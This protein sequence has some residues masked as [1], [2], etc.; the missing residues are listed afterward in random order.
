M[1]GAEVSQLR[2][3]KKGL[4]SANPINAAFK[5]TYPIYYMEFLFQNFILSTDMFKIRG[6]VRGGAA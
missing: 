3:F 4:S 1:K 2:D 5:I 6:G